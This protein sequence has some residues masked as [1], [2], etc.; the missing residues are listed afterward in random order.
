[1]LWPA[2]NLLAFAAIPADLRILYGNV[3]GIAWCCYVSLACAAAGAPPPP[4]L[5]KLE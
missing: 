5:D 1:M 2:A 3:V 4:P